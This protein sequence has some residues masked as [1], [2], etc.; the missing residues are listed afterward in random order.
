MLAFATN[1]PDEYRDN[2]AEVIGLL[3]SGRAAPHI[4]S[5]FSLDDV[6]AALQL[7]GDGQA[8]GKVVLD[9]SR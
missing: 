8:I 1:A 9:V 7:V 4:G 6:A 3:A 2:E 5:R